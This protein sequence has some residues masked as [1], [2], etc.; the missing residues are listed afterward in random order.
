MTEDIGSDR[1]K[2]PSNAEIDVT[3]K[4]AIMRERMAN[5][6]QL[7][8]KIVTQLDIVISKISHVETSLMLGQER[9]RAIEGRATDTSRD[10]ESIRS[11]LSTM[12]NASAGIANKILG[13]IGVLGFLAG[14]ATWIKEWVK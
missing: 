2:R 5:A 9:F 7:N 12:E 1:H 14:A 13:G 10:L 4:L 11:R 6:K 3:E 8:E